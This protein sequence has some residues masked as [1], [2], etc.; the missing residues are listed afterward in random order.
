MTLLDFLFLHH[1]V[2]QTAFYFCI[3]DYNNIVKSSFLGANSA[4]IHGD[5]WNKMA[6]F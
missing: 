1:F 3:S 2:S 6:S 5:I 4:L